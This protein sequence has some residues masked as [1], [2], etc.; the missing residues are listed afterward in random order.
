MTHRSRSDDLLLL[1]NASSLRIT[2]PV[3]CSLFSPCALILGD[4]SADFSCADDHERASH[5]CTTSVQEQWWIRRRMV[6]IRYVV[7]VDSLVIILGPPR[8]PYSSL[9]PSK[10]GC[11]Q[12]NPDRQ[13]TRTASTLRFHQRLPPTPS[14]VGKFAK[15]FCPSPSAATR[16]RAQLSYLPPR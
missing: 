12:T 10:K 14:A 16:V 9:I 15:I 8:T 4:P 7:S 11:M 13:V 2:A 3:T 6:R 5:L 1:C